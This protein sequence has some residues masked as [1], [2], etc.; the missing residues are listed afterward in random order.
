MIMV[1]HRQHLLYFGISGEPH[2]DAS[3][4]WKSGNSGRVRSRSQ[5]IYHWERVRNDG[6]NITEPSPLSLLLR[7]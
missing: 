3:F 4:T 7:L 1:S 2:R 5:Q 6:Q